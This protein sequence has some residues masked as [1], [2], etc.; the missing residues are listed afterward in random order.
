MSG[1]VVSFTKA[2]LSIRNKTFRS[3][4]FVTARWRRYFSHSFRSLGWQTFFLQPKTPPLFT[5]IYIFGGFEQDLPYPQFLRFESL[6]GSLLFFH[7]T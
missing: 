6:C 1:N 7:C 5:Y 4:R 2:N 3:N